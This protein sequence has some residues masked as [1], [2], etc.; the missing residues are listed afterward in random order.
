MFTCL[1]SLPKVPLNPVALRCKHRPRATFHWALA[2]TFT[3]FCH[4]LAS[5]VTFL[6]F[7]QKRGSA[8]TPLNGLSRA[9]AANALSMGGDAYRLGEGREQT[10]YSDASD[11]GRN[12]DRWRQPI[13][14]SRNVGNPEGNILLTSFSSQGSRPSVLVILHIGA[15][16]L[17]YGRHGAEH[18]IADRPKGPRGPHCITR[19]GN[20]KHGG[21]SNG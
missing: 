3:D 10:P 21:S 8:P 2:M 1:G 17:R 16:L 4:A 7:T 5:A 15:N 18:V 11:L 20:L 6:I 12:L 14:G 19:I 13:D 9:L